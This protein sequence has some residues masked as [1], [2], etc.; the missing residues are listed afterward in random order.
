MIKASSCP[1]ICSMPRLYG[2]VPAHAIGDS[3]YLIID[4]QKCVAE[5]LLQVPV[6]DRMS[7][8]LRFALRG[9]RCMMIRGLL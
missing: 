4:T 9:E 5:Y 8:R 7:M 1:T 3:R 2:K 6:Q